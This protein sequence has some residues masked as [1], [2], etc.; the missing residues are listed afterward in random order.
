MYVNG[1][2]SVAP[3]LVAPYVGLGINARLGLGH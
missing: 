1:G 3:D 2:V